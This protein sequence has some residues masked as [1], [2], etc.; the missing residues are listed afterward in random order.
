VGGK[1]ACTTF[2]SCTGTHSSYSLPGTG[3]SYSTAGAGRVA[4]PLATLS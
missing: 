3:L 4:K 2:N 1:F